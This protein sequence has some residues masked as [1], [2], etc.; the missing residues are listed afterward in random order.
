MSDYSY[1]NEDYIVDYLRDFYM[2]T[3]PLLK[4][5]EH[6]AKAE[7][8][9]IVEPETA[10][11]LEVLLKT[12]KPKRILE[13]GTAIGYSA[14]RMMRALDGN[15]HIYTIERDYYMAQRAREF[16]QQS[17]YQ[18]FHLMEGDAMDILPELE[19]SFDFIFMDAAK[20][21]YSNFFAMASRRLEPEGLIISDNVLFRGMVASNKL[22]ERRKIT[23][24]KD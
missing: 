21:Q 18:N 8:I 14:I 9:P 7:E 20:A 22:V 13:I 19:L 23:I 17:G 1:I 12:K 3:D 4:E 5:M 2:T 15:V 11:F 16:F 6:L 10:Q 24:V